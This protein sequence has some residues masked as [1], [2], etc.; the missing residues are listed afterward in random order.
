MIS[1]ESAVP[2]PRGQ[3]SRKQERLQLTRSLRVQGK[4]WVEVAEVVRRRYRVNARVA[5]RYA[6]GWSQRQAADEWNKRW[7]DELKTF[8]I[9]SY[10]EVWPSSS[11]HA[12]S[13]DNFGRLAELYEC[14]VSDLLVDLPDFR[15]LDTIAGPAERPATVQVI[16]RQE[17]QQKIRTHPV[18]LHEEIVMSAEESARFVRRAG[19]AVTPE[20]LEQL[21]TDVKW[22]ATEYL[23]RPPYTVFRPVAALRR[24]V[25]DMIDRNPRPGL[26]TDLYRVAGQLSALLAHASNDLGQPYA[27]D[28]HARTAWLCADLA[29]NN[30]TRA[31]IRW[32][33]SHVAYWRG[34]YL[35]AAELARSG[36]SLTGEVSDLLRLSSQEARALAAAQ[37]EREANRALAAASD[38]R[39]RVADGARPAGVFYFAP[40]KAAYYASEV[41]L[42]LGGEAN[43]RLAATEA[44]EALELLAAAPAREQSAEL[45]AAAQLD[46]IAAQLALNDLDGADAH[47]QT[48]LQLPSENRTVPIIGRMAKIDQTLADEAF[49]N[50]TLASDLREQIAVFCAYPAARELPQLPAS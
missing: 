40:G 10:W 7:P 5:F 29:G 38:A 1:Q 11:G 27:A 44:E 20:V 17:A 28:S 8:K 43:F 46:L 21:D 13:F 37:D 25:F 32:V 45:I 36:Q 16:P 18:S 39:E 6:H 14:A 48:V 31:Y 22:L 42:S 24:D 41:R 19:V 3:G 9:F 35:D 49:E 47:A 23:R 50:V 12:P 30:T 2:D 34:E 33:Q 4:S 26:L 15:H